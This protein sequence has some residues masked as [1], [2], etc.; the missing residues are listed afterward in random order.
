MNKTNG[1]AQTVP[2][3]LCEASVG[4]AYMPA[5]PVPASASVRHPG[6]LSATDESGGGKPPPYEGV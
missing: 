4:R 6:P 3:L 2:F 5:D 1:T